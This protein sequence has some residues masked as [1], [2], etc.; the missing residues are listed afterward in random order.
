MV[1][2]FYL[3]GRIRLSLAIAALAIL[4]APVTINETSATLFLLPIAFVL[5]VVFSRKLEGGAPNAVSTLIIGALAVA[6]FV[7]GYNQ[8]YGKRW[9]GDI[10]DLVTKGEILAYEYQGGAKES[11]KGVP[12]T[13]RIDSILNPIGVLGKDPATMLMGVGIGNVSVSFSKRL[14]GEY[15]KEFG[16]IGARTS[17]LS[18]LLWETGI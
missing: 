17:A 6:L 9:G 18:L 12:E 15:A 2:G 7:V 3:K 4:L 1:V 10:L 5:P 14:E 8:M 11:R 16:E 13:G